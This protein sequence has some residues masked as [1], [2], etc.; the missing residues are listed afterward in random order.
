MATLA[1]GHTLSDP[2]SSEES[3]AST[4]PNVLVF[5][6]DD[7]GAG[8]LQV[9]V[10]ACIGCTFLGLNFLVI[11]GAGLWPSHNVYA[12]P[13][14]LCCRRSSVHSMVLEDVTRLYECLWCHEHALFTR[15]S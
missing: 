11:L 1:A 15:L 12:K 7:L 2:V 6:A 14:C 5:F 3:T 13:R 10:C 4:K 9:D 8:D